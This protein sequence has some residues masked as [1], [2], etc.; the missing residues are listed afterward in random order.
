MNAPADELKLDGLSVRADLEQSESQSTGAVAGFL[1]K[2]GR[3]LGFGPFGV[4]LLE[5]RR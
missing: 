2:A 4:E 5:R 3:L 1:E